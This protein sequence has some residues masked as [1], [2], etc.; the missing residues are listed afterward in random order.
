MRWAEIVRRITIV[1]CGSFCFFGYDQGMIAGVNASNHYVKLMGFGYVDENDEP[2][3]T[4]GLLEGGIIAIYYFGTLIGCFLG[5]I[6]GDDYGRI[7][8]VAL[9]A[10]IG[11]VGAALQ[12]TAQNVSWMCIA[13]IINGV[14]TGVLSAVIPVWTT[15]VCEHSSRGQMISTEFTSNIFGV[16]IAYWLAYGL[17]FIDGGNSQWRWRF[18]IA[19]QIIPLIILL[20]VIFFFPE[21]PRWLIKDGKFERARFILSR[22]RGRNYH[23]VETEYLA[24][25]KSVANEKRWGHRPGVTTNYWTMITGTGGGSMHITRRV[26]LIIWLQIIQEWVGVAC[27]TVYAPVM[28]RNAGFAAQTATFIS[29]INNITYCLSTLIPVLYLDQYGRRKFLHVG[30]VLQAIFMAAAGGCSKMRDD[31][32]GARWGIGATVSIFLFTFSFGATWLC[33]PW[34]YQTEIFPT[35]IRV[36]GASFGVIGW[37]LGSGWLTLLC[38]IMFQRIGPWTLVVF[39]CCS[40]STMP[41]VWALCPETNQCT[42]ED[43]EYL[44]NLKSPWAWDAEKNYAEKIALKEAE[45]QCSNVE[46]GAA[47]VEDSA[48][49]VEGTAAEVEDLQ[50]GDVRCRNSYQLKKD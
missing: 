3:S 21:S 26:Y 11:I 49:E 14:G 45:N 33:V 8:G 44:F 43:I 50:S 23:D 48:A 25:N 32:G 5:G 4:N 16:V 10:V 13:R 37:S 24:I 2:R 40:L 34:I 38:P 17:S 47:E 9:G 35:T 42:L 18:P 15:E 39:A 36:K 1:A 30:A 6:V 7:K 46:N 41:I 29:G 31:G 27:V 12:C 19:F 28:F 22:I 20:I